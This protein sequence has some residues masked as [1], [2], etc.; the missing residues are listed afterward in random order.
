MNILIID[1]S[2]AF[3]GALKCA[4]NEAELLSDNHKTVFVLHH[5]SSQVRTLRE[6]GFKVHLLPMVEIKRSLSILLLYPIMLLRN[7]VALRRIIKEEQI[8]I[9]QVNDFYNLLGA[10]LKKT[11]FNG[12]LITYVRF[13]PNVMPSI[14]CKLW[15]AQAVKHADKVVA[16]SDAVKEQLPD[17]PNVTR[18][19]DPVKLSETLPE[20]IYTQKETLSLLYLG[21]YIQGKGQEYALEAF[22]K[23][24]E[25]NNKIRLTFIGGDMG[26]EKNKAFKQ[27]LQARTKELA[28]DDVVSYS[29]FNPNV[30]AVIKEADI[31]L[32]FSEAES[33]SMTCLE[34]AYYGTPLIA[35]RCGGPQEIITHEETGLIVPVKDTETM[36]TAIL[37]MAA[38]QQL[39]TRYALAGKQYVR[40]KFSIDTFKHKFE[41]IIAETG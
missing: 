4:I 33:F 25:Q 21:N 30:E 35:T 5:Q 20:K 14:L 24:Y 28:L 40:N 39:R 37:K 17:A 31:M 29:A 13:L 38:D 11:G 34:A 8:D 41:Q 23:A 1:N 9:V 26:L 6:K 27:K 36:T 7:T 32:N 18:I 22:A 16:V 12:K 15:V 10:M 19:Y 2:I 3:T